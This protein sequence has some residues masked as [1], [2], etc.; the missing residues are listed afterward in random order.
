MSSIEK[1]LKMVLKPPRT[2]SRTK[3]LPQTENITEECPGTT[4]NLA[5]VEAAEP[6][7]GLASE[8][9]RDTDNN[10]LRTIFFLTMFKKIFLI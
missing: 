4:V 7:T 5:P 8:E 9:S 2:R 1:T 10:C 3:I 6:V